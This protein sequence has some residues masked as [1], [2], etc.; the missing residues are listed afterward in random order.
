MAIIVDSYGHT[1][2]G[3]IRGITEPSD[4]INDTSKG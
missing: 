4:D 1:S 3:Y 2:F